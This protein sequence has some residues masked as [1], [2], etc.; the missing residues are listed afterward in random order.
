MRI[1]LSVTNDLVTDQRVHK[2]CTTLLQHGYEVKSVGRRLRNSPDLQRPY[3]TRRMRLLFNKGFLFYAEFNLRLFWYLLFDRTDL[4][5]ANDT[6]TLLANYLASKLRRKP[7]VFDAHEM[8]P[9]VPEVIHR[10]KVHAVWQ[11]LEDFLF[12]KLTHAYTV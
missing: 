4:Y 11:G 6:D 12:P 10:K 8:F 7:L 5:L 2:V 9:E 1:T 3:A